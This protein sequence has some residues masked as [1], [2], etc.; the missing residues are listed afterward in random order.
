MSQKENL[1]YL[2]NIK[3]TEINRF[4]SFKKADI[5]LKLKQIKI[6]LL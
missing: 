3:K 2:S 6:K 1:S 4:K 5:N